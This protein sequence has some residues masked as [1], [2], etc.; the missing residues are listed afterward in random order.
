VSIDANTGPVGLDDVNHTVCCRP[1]WGLCGRG[2]AGWDFVPEGE[3]EANDCP[4]C[5][6][7]EGRPCAASFCRVRRLWRRLTRKRWS[8]ECEQGSKR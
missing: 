1:D 2:V 8:A 4:H 7:R 6:A 3:E 5:I